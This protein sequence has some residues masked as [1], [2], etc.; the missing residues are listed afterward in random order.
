M[1]CVHFRSETVYPYKNNNM[2][3]KQDTDI[4]YTSMDMYCTELKIVTIVC[5]DTHVLLRSCLSR[6]LGD[7]VIILFCTKMGKICI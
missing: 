4:I 7:R 3:G 2:E 5:W 6:P 1:H